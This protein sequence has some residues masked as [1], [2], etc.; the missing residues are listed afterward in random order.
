MASLL[1]ALGVLMPWIMPTTTGIYLFA[2]IAGFGY[3]VYSSVDQALN[4]DVLPDPETAGKD[5][6]ILNMSTT[7]GQMSGPVITSVIVT[8]TG[9]YTLVFPVSIGCAVV[10]CFS[11]LAIRRVR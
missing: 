11:I 10:G 1:F 3:A 2:L 8:W 9:A 6:G 4:V 7:L 5:L